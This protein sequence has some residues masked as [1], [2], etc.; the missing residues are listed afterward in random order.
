MVKCEKCGAEFAEGI[1]HICVTEESK[2]TEKTE[3]E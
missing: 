3:Q 2:A 1:E